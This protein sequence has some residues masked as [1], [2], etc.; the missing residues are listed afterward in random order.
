MNGCFQQKPSLRA[1]F[2]NPSRNLSHFHGAKWAGEH[3][4]MGISEGQ[5]NE[6]L[7]LRIQAFEAVMKSCIAELQISLPASAQTET[8]ASEGLD[9]LL[10][11]HDRGQF[12]RDLAELSALAKAERPLGLMVIDFD[13]FKNIND[14]YGHDAG[15]D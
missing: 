6:N 12:E 7:K 13:N 5:R 9:H 14:N 4:V 3:N 1:H 10:E 2:G 8:G 15:D 11:I